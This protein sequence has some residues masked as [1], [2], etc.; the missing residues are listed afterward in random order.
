MVEREREVGGGENLH[1]ILQ[2]GIKLDVP[3]LCVCVFCFL[4][5]C[6]ILDVSMY[7]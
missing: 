5:F 4:F 6:L 2:I 3:G 7:D 1:I